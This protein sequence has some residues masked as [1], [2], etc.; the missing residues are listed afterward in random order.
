MFSRIFIA[1]AM[2]LWLWPLAV[3]AAKAPVQSP[4]AA[5]EKLPEPNA[6]VLQGLNKVT[7]HISRLEGP[8]G[9]VM[10]FGKLEIIARRCWKSPPEDSP[11]NAALLEIRELKPCE[12]PQQ[13]FLGWMFS[14]SPGLS[15][16]EHPVYDITVLSCQVRKD[17][18]KE[19]KPEKLEKPDKPEKTDNN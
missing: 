13:I 12:G 14:S 7:G 9:T 18:E 8:L 11:E 15:S 2:L 1:V 10:D 3:M 5:E 4:P 17:P 16:L 6:V 19:D